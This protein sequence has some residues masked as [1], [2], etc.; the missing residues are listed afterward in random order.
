MVGS[1]QHGRCNLTF[2]LLLREPSTLWP[3]S[4]AQSSGLGD[5]LLVLVGEGHWIFCLSWLPGRR[6]L[7]GSL[8][9]G[10]CPPLRVA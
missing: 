6:R 8:S 5:C 1:V 4:K 10:S 7:C 3:E 2:G 9:L